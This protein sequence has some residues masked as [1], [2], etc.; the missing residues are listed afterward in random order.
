MAVSRTVP[1]EATRRLAGLLVGRLLA[2]ALLVG[3]LGLFLALPLFSVLV[4]SVVGREQPILLFLSRGQI[5]DLLVLWGRS[6]TLEYWRGL[7]AT[8]LYFLSLVN[9]LKLGL[10][11]SGTATVLGFLLAYAVTRTAMPGRRLVRALAVI[12]MIMPPFIG[13]YAFTLLLGD[14]G[15]VT[16]IAEVYG[17][18]LPLDI[19]TPTGV[20][21][22]QVYIFTPFVFLTTAAVLDRSDPALE[23]ASESLGAPGLYTFCRVTLPLATPGLAAGALLAFIGSLADFGTP[24]VLAPRRFPLLP[25]EAYRELVSY[26][27]WGMAAT[28]SAVMIVL[29]VMG[30]LAY[31]KV[32][33]GAR[34]ETVT[35][36]RRRTARLVQNRAVVLGLT[37]YAGLFLAVPLA[38]LAVIGLMAVT[39][40]WGT[41]IF[42]S[43]YTLEHVQYALVTGPAALRNSLVLS[44]LAIVITGVYGAILAR[45]IHRRHLGASRWLDALIMVPLAIPGT[46][47]A[48]GLILTFNAGP[49]TL[50]QTPWLLLVSYCVRRLPYAVRATLASLQQI[51]R[52]LEESSLSLGASPLFTLRWVIFPLVLPG[53]LAGAVLV[54]I[55]TM[56]SISDAILL[57]A[58]GWAPLSVEIYTRVLASEVYRAAAFAVVLIATAGLLR[59][60]I[61]RLTEHDALNV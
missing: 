22:V 29:A 34:F 36:R 7:L 18:R 46:A 51:E 32:V 8:D 45:L 31:Q 58:P 57:Y 41:E 11:V 61:S 56:E 30:V 10:A 55:T 40:V 14:R 54:L 1:M 9:S 13:A 53:I 42:P 52:G 37:L 25:V 24:V 17:Y 5:G 44:G 47:V 48:I 23:E 50:V 33:A 35:G 43:R 28:L 2:G 26:N 27:N 16:R 49:I 6:A 12:P 4:V 38:V 20:W 21:L 39:E 3:P 15:F 59:I 60:V 19:F